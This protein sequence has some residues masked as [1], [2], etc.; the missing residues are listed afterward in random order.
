MAAPLRTAC[1]LGLLVALALPAS[2]A[3]A[4]RVPLGFVGTMADGPIAE[5]GFDPL[6][7]TSVMVASGVESIRPVFHWTDAQP[8]AT[9]DAV[10][11]AE[12]SAYRLVD[13]VPTSFEPFDR[14]VAA[15]TIRRLRVL[16]VV[17]TAPRW[18]AKY[19]GRFA[20]PPAGTAAYASFARALAARYGPGGSF[21][22]ENRS[23]PRHRPIRV[24]QL[25]NEP[26][27][28]TS[29][30]DK[31]WPKPYVDLLRAG[32]AAI[33]DV[34]PGARTVLAGFA[35]YSWR[36]LAAVY[37]VPGAR[38]LFDEVAI[39]PYTG[40]VGGVKTILERVR[41]TMRRNGDRRKPIA[42]T[43]F[44]WPS[45]KGKAK[46]FGIETTE[47]GQAAR[48]RK[49][50]IMLGRQRRRLG[51]SSVYWYTWIA[52]ERGAD[53]IFPYSALRRLEPDGATVSK[54]ALRAFRRTA[55]SLERCRV[56]SL[57][58]T[59]CAQPARRDGRISSPP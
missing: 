51:I 15:A 1:L 27:L 30:S 10:P 39:H 11:P 6:P 56:K 59:R 25:W 35:N 31:R 52:R 23:L 40:Q 55:L 3:A 8:Y 32:R 33:R 9:I 37:R 12:R 14:L 36:S 22:A 13:G 2:A 5:P 16:P 19:P 28:R 50:L 29:W 57:L 24:W 47:R 17:T 42:V 21:W 54:P 46:G 18:A 58:A 20:S 44:G 4:P 38:R 53:S 49:A 45:A 48:A 34:D 26:N 43:E 7:E 41:R